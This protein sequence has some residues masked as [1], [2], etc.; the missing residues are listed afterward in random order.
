M[1]KILFLAMAAA[2]MV[3]CS[4]NEEFENAGKQA[5][6]K[7]QSLVKAGTKATV[8][9]TGTLETFTVCAYKTDGLYESATDLATVFMPATLVNKDNEENW[10]P[11]TTYYWPA[12]G[13]VQFFAASPKQ[14]IEVSAGK[15]TPTFNYTIKDVADQEDLVAA[16]LIDEDKTS[17]KLVL[18]FK[19]LL[20]QINITLKGATPDFTYTVSKLVIKGAKNVGTFTFDGTESTIGRWGGQKVTGSAPVYEVPLT[21]SVSVAPTTASPDETKALE[22]SGNALFMLMPQTLEKVTMEITYMAAPTANPTN[23]TFN[24]TKILNLEGEWGMSQNIRY[25]LSLTNDASPIEF[26]APKVDDTWTSKD[27]TVTEPTP[28]P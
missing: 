17:G 5:E 21:S 25:T 4:Q 6:I 2:A 23:Y 1:K 11:E 28:A 12:E 15:K 18:P 20:S 7:F 10:I 16:S 22:T 9:T 13:K 26:N 14:T 19:H 3:S 8:I 27:G 24:D